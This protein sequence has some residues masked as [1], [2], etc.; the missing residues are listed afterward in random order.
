VLGAEFV[1][2][3]RERG[4]V[5]LR[6]LLSSRDIQ[7]LRDE[8]DAALRSAF[9]ADYGRNTRTEELGEGEIAAEGNFLP[10]MADRSPLSMALVADDPRLLPAA[11]ALLGGEAVPVSPALATC[12]V[13]DTPWHNDP[14]TGE[15]WV[16]FNAYLDP[17]DAATGALQIAVRSQDHRG[18]AFDASDADVDVVQTEPG[19]VIAFDPRA[20]HASFGGT[21]RLRWCVDYAPV[22]PARDEARAEATLGLVEELSSWPHPDAWPVWRTWSAQVSSERGRRAV[23]ALRNLGVCLDE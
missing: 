8:V 15:R 14:G 3:F 18:V 7:R 4:Y 20:F 10:L 13:S 19:D 11:D 9:G 21:R 6:G 23:L 17:V 12:M 22:P 16:R 5:V 2:E 1:S